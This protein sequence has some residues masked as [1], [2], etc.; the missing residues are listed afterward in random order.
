MTQTGHL[1]KATMEKLAAA[2]TKYP[3]YDKLFADG[4]LESTI[5]VGFDETRSG[6]P[7]YHTVEIPKVIQGLQNQGYTEIDPKTA[8]A[9]QL[10]ADGIDPAKVDKDLR[11]FTKKFVY[12]GKDVQS[13]VKL[14]TPSTP[15][16]KE[17]FATAMGSSEVVLYGGHGRYGS[18]P[19][20]DDIHS[21]ANLSM[22][23]R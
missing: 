1:D 10:K 20:F 14:I 12:N 17:K 7:G 15:H 19:D 13:I 4:K 18:G 16:A 9:A 22:P 11:Y 5:A 6:V 8:S 23:P 2:S 3:E 21:P